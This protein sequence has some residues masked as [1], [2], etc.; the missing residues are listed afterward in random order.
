MISTLPK[1]LSTNDIKY[2]QNDRVIDGPSSNSGESQITALF[3]KCSN[4]IT[5]TFS[6]SQ[7]DLVEKTSESAEANSRNN[8]YDQHSGKFKESKDTNNESS[9]HFSFVIGGGSPSGKVSWTIKVVPNNIDN[10]LSTNNQQSLSLR[11]GDWR[12]LS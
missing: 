9:K 1:P 6:T 5:K 7:S 11:E 10:A 4:G 8:S 12:A 2:T 3:K